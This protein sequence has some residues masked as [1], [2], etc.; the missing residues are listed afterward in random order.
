MDTILVVDDQIRPRRLLID[1]LEDAGFEVSEASDG[2][3]GWERFRRNPPD[4]VI[5]DMMMPRCD[6]FELLR[7]IRTHS[8]VPVIVFSGYGSVQSAA[9]AIKA[10]AQE[11]ISSLDIELDELVDLVRKAIKKKGAISSLP[12]LETRIAGASAATQRLRW[13]ITGLAPLGAP[14][15]V[16]GEPG[17]G[18]TTVIEAIH[19]LGSSVA[20][21]LTRIEG[22]DFVPPCN[23]ES[24]GAIYI[25]NVEGLS[26]EA[27]TYWAE[28]LARSEMH[29]FTGKLRVLATSDQPA[30]L[31]AR[32][33]VRSRLFSTLLRFNI[34]V[35][36][37]RARLGD[38]PLIAAE[39]V[40]RIGKT[41]G[42][43][44]VRLSP[45]STEFLE[46]CHFPGNVKQLQQVLERAIAFTRGPTI[47][48]EPLQRIVG[49]LDHSVANIRD[50]RRELERHQL[51][52]TIRETGGNIT[53]T[54]ETLGK[55][56][57]AIYRLME[58]YRIALRRPD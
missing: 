32:H 57:A 46:N 39:L 30:S 5:T 34:E 42:R 23:L 47:E 20:G 49:E 38:A 15:L 10:G 48:R 36:P 51:L 41:L 3:E 33:G 45:E 40:D 55:S 21:K 19:E 35:P 31:V 29:S 2:E 16:T 24:P 12:E 17:S 43:H 9:E 22:K 4:L 1:E 28:R 18:R 44:D 56:R 25:E 26:T 50:E 11:F 27:Q 13:Q 37:L 6:G 7:R 54:A 58:K 8:E 53:H 52:T 14:V